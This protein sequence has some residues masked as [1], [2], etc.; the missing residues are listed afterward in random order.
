MTIET[1][2]NIGDKVWYINWNQEIVNE[3]VT[4][5]RTSSARGFNY[6]DIEYGFGNAD[7]KKERHL[8]DTKEELLKSL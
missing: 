2:Y 7:W 3:S 5:I 4:Y 1:K 6:I 8:F